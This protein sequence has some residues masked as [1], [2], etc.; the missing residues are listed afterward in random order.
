MKKNLLLAISVIAITVTMISCNKDNNSHE[1]SKYITIDA[2]VS[3]LTRA[4]ATAFQ[5]DDQVSIYAWTGSTSVVQ[6]P[7]VIDNIVNTYDGSGWIPSQQM[8]WK[9]EVTSHY[10]IGVYPPKA[11]T[12]FTADYYITLPD[13][14]VATV[15][16]EGRKATDAGGVV[17]M[18]FDHITARL[19]VNLTFRSEFGGTPTVQYIT[20]FAQPGAMV[21]YLTKTT[22]VSGEVI[23]KDL[24]PTAVNTAYSQFFA[25]QTVNTINI[26]IGNT[27]Y[28]Y[29]NPAGIA[30]VAGKIQ[31][32]NLIVG[33]DKIEL[34]SVTINDWGTGET[35][36]GGEA[37]D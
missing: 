15:L 32:V 27:K 36:N 8:L 18:I 24:M 22:T 25:P 33:R 23:E 16:G 9:D 6:T 5:K 37:L 26:T 31:T 11:I 20:T 29:N 3:S 12:D 35:I 30:L 7:L 2:G 17:P 34:G 14:L 28:V 1:V 10:F 4:T 19:D 21:N 13:V